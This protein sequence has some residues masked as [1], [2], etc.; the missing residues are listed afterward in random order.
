[1]V[2][3]AVDVRNSMA[4]RWRED[5]ITL[6]RLQVFYAQRKIVM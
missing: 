5:F 2:L 3:D 4:I 1:M 6:S